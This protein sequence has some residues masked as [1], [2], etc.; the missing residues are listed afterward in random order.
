MK[1]LECPLK[2][3]GQTGRTFNARY[4]EHVHD[5]RSNNGNSRYSNHVLNMG[6]TYVW[7]NNRYYGCHKNRKE[8]Q[9]LEY[10]RKVSHLEN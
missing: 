2:Y 10:L 4:K 1:C 6:H 7:H 8:R 5:I 9:T 3:V